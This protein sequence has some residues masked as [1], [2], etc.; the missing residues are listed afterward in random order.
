MIFRMI[1]FE[2][3]NCLFTRFVYLMSGTVLSMLKAIIPLYG[4]GLV[5]SGS[6]LGDQNPL[7]RVP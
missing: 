2:T 3:V 4:G 1:S 7:F 5:A 6:Y